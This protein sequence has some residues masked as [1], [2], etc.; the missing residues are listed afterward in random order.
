MKLSDSIKITHYNTY[1]FIPWALAVLDHEVVLD[2]T[3]IK[4]KCEMLYLESGACSRSKIGEDQKWL[5][6]SWLLSFDVESSSS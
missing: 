3:Q 2:L 6:E 1:P 5:A 4:L